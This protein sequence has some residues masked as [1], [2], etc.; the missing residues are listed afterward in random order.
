MAA[1]ILLQR[2][3]DYN[4]KDIDS[5]VDAVFEHFG[6]VGRFIKRGASVLLKVNLVSGHASDRRVTTD[7]AVVR[8]VARVA[9]KAGGRP[10]IADSPGIDSFSR[11]I[12]V[13]GIA[14]VAQELGVPC[15]ELTDPVRVSPR[16]ELSRRVVESDVII[17]LPKMKTHAQMLLTMGVKNMFGCVVGRKKAEWHYNIGLRRDLFA[18]LL[19]EIWLAAR[20]ALTIMDG[21][22]GMDGR[23]P[24][25]GQPFPY[26]VLAGAEDALTMDLHLCKMVGAR[27]D[28]YPLWRAAYAKNLP[29]TNLSDDDI[30]GDF[31]PSHIWNAAIPKLDNLSL[32]PFS[33]GGYLARAMTSRPVHVSARCLGA[34]KCGSCVALC[35]AH[36]IS[37]G[38]NHERDKKLRFDYDKCIRCYCCHEMCPADAIDFK[39]G[40]IMKLG[41]VISR[42]RN[43]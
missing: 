23:G 13:S 14:A 15:E 19:I 8:A 39:E 27:L 28:D 30:A 22:W 36:A 3:E 41:K 10:V 1:K 17:N 40:L 4:Q 6:G 43:L 42:I 2:R 38:Q 35:A 16:L 21:V 9:L 7:P 20:P 26:G 29:Q 37:F 24:T 5:A 18:E 12:R 33:N 32:V 25:H 34:D 31:S 11:A